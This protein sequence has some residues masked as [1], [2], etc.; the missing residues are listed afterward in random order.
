MLKPRK[1]LVKA[2]LKEDKLLVFTAKTQ[3]FYQDYSKQLFYVVL[4]VIILGGGIGAVIWSNR[5]SEE[6]SAFE[7]LLARDSYLR[8]NLDET[9]TKADSIVTDFPG[10]CAAATAWLLKGRVH[11]QRGEY[12]QAVDAFENLV[13]K[14]ADE[15]YLAFSAYYALGSI[16]HGKSEFS[17]A[18]EYYEQAAKRYPD[19]F[20]APNSL[21]E[22]GV[23]L[24]KIS[25]FENAKQVYRLILA[26]YS[27][28]RVADKARKNLAALEFMQ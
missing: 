2:K 27:K 25:R 17:I 16:S 20:N 6:N 4:I 9:L 14:H 19:H 11:Q 3:Q 8:G 28:S 18:A 10:T 15:R 26:N 12:D 21:F 22:A 5:T 1:R 13:K 7:E 23:C 24:E